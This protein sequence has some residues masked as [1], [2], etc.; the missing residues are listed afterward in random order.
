MKNVKRSIAAACVLALGLVLCTCG[1]LSVSDIIRAPEL[2]LGSLN[3]TG[4][5]FTGV[6]GVCKINVENPNAI[7]IPLPKID[8]QLFIESGELVNGAIESSDTIGARKTSVIDV[9]FHVDYAELYAAV[10]AVKDAAKSGASKTNFKIAVKASFNLPVLGEIALP[11]EADGALPLLRAPKFSGAKINIE[12]LDFSGISL[13]CHV[14]VENPNPFP[15]P[16]PSMDWDYAVNKQSFLKGLQLADNVIP[17]NSTKPVDINLNITFA[18]LFKTFAVLLTAKE[19]AGAMAVKSNLNSVP[20]FQEETA[21]FEVGSMIPLVRP[22]SISFS[23]ITM[24]NVSLASI[25]F[26]IG[27]EVENKNSFAMNVDSL[28]YNLTVNGSKWA[29][30]AAPRRMTVG[31]DQKV[32]IPIDLSVNALSLVQEIAALVAGRARNI[33]YTCSGG[34]S[35][36]SDYPGLS[37]VNLPLNFSGTTRF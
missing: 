2:S 8:W 31:P 25:T 14:D 24:Q 4:L 26:R 3:L 20:A 18:D 32:T 13:N 1:S 37:P 21:A 19:A 29:E 30:G 12:K 17:A 6:D 36:S 5:S 23:G 15:F 9:P 27:F 10:V 33:P 34:I 7:N 22:P 28:S 11:F 16:F 35:V